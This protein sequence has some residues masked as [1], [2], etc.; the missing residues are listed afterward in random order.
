MSVKTNCCRILDT[1]IIHYTLLEYEV[2]EDSL[3][4]VTVANKLDLSPEQ[5]FKTLVLVGDSVKYFVAVIPGNE[6]LSLKKAALASGNK[7][8]SM[9]PLKELQSLTGYIRGGC[10]PIGMKKQ[11]PTYIEETAQL[12]DEISISPGQRGLQILI[13]PTDIITITNGE[14]AA[15]I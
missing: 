8:C 12:F 13:K 5:V 14:Y 7:S 15:L 11:F 9:L 4:A 10:S 6:E 1:H 3:D 2:D